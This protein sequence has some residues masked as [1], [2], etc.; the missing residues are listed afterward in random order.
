MMMQLFSCIVL[1]L[2]SVCN[3][4]TPL[5]ASKKMSTSCPRAFDQTIRYDANLV[6]YAGTSA[7]IGLGNGIEVGFDAMLCS[8]IL[9][10]LGNTAALCNQLKGAIKRGF[11][12]WALRH[13][14]LY[15]TYTELKGNETADSGIYSEVMIKG[16]DWGEF[17]LRENRATMG[18]ASWDR[19]GK[20][21]VRKTGTTGPRKKKKS[22]KHVHPAV[23]T[24]NPWMNWMFDERAADFTKKKAHVTSAENHDWGKVWD[25]FYFLENTIA[26]EMGHILGI[27]HNDD[28]KSFLSNIV[29]DNTYN[30]GYIQISPTTPC[31][32]LHTHR[33]QDADRAKGAWDA[34]FKK[35]IMFSR[36][37]RGETKIASPTQD[38]L[39]ALFFAY[40]SSKRSKKWGTQPLHLKYFTKTKLRAFGRDHLGKRC[41]GLAMRT[42]DL[43]TT[44]MKD[45][46]ECLSSASV[47]ES[48]IPLKTMVKNA[49]KQFDAECLPLKQLYASAKS[50]LSAVRKQHTR[51]KAANR[52][53]AEREAAKLKA[54]TEAVQQ[55]LTAK[56][57]REGNSEPPATISDETKAALPSNALPSDAPDHAGIVHHFDGDVDDDGIADR[58]TDGD[59]IPDAID[60]GLDVLADLL[61]EIMNGSNTYDGRWDSDCDGI[62]DCDDDAHDKKGCVHDDDA[63][64]AEL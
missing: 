52:E 27:G 16:G 58:D 34:E 31:K 17:A 48:L 44:E 14:S 39:A 18:Y 32:A 1:S 30:V 5:T 40:P 36:G 46:V 37:D 3:A 28:S 13:D 38:D 20:G 29:V 55:A 47:G 12:F 50:T 21:G 8:R 51:D 57:D 64:K 63:T 54:M 56:R 42:K 61:E 11:E 22:G 59:G 23:I 2:F 24:L 15:F 33:R 53:F 9:N 10:K 62:P 41:A 49:C 60:D 25:E 6:K 19:A 7:T 43:P 26:H 35:S 4:F 45:L